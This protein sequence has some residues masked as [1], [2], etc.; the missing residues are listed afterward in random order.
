MLDHYAP[1][2]VEKV[3]VAVSQKRLLL[4]HF[5]SVAHQAFD[6]KHVFNHVWLLS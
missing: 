2:I 1:F 4:I 5:S 3:F 6:S